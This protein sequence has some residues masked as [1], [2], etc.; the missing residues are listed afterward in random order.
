MDLEKQEARLKRQSELLKRRKAA[1]SGGVDNALSVL[2][3]KQAAVDAAADAL[4]QAK[5]E[6]RA[7]YLEWSRQ[8]QLAGQRVRAEKSEPAGEGADTDA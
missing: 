6:A 7:A 2:R 5:D 4:K 1:I 3:E 8:M